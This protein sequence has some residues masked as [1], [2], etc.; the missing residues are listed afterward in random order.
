MRIELDG[1][2]ELQQRQIV[3]ERRRIVLPVHYDPLHVPAD[4]PLALPV[5]GDVEF[6]E[7]GDQRGQEAGLTMGRRHHV[8]VPYE[9]SAALVLGEETEPRQLPD[10]HLPREL[11]ECGPLAAH[12][13]ARLHQGTLPALWKEGGILKGLLTAGG[14]FGEGFGCDVGSALCDRHMYV[15]ERE[16]L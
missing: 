5:P 11:S 7:D 16:Y 4:G 13:A 2:F 1:M 8:S 10:E 14:A 6:P 3:L 15:V 9:H 12:D